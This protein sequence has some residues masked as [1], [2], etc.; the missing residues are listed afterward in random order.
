MLRLVEDTP[1]HHFRQVSQGPD[2]IP[3]LSQTQVAR[4]DPRGMEGWNPPWLPTALLESCLDHWHPPDWPGLAPP[5]F[6]IFSPLPEQ[7]RPSQ[8]L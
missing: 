7:M 3:A 5:S 6:V 8:Q 4:D 1:G 2:P